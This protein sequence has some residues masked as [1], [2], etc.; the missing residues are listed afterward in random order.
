MTESSSDLGLASSLISEKQK[1]T[2]PAPFP[3]SG[4]ARKIRARP[5][6]PDSSSGN[7][8]LQKLAGTAWLAVLRTVLPPMA[9]DMPT[10]TGV[11]T[12]TLPA[13]R[14]LS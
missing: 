2:I 4:E 10:N 1:P 8:R 11:P 14:L 13:N 3:P 6:Q 9:A 5:P 12:G 7:S